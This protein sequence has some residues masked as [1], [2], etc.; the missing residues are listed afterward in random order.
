M[1][2]ER[3]SFISNLTARVAA[4]IAGV[5]LALAFGAPWLLQDAPPSPEAVF[6]ANVCCFKAPAVVAPGAAQRVAPAK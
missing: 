1:T 5:V 4:L 6:A 3:T 2:A